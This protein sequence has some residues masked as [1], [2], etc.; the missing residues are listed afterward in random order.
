MEAPFSAELTGSSPDP[1]PDGE[2]TETRSILILRHVNMNTNTLKCCQ[3]MK[4][5]SGLYYVTAVPHFP[6]AAATFDLFVFACE[7]DCFTWIRAETEI[8]HKNEHVNIHEKSEK[9]LEKE[10]PINNL[11]THHSV[12]PEPQADNQTADYS[13]YFI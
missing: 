6:A 3:Y 11:I 5:F 9:E 7:T 13:C 10:N 4:V 2:K 1:R 8:I 12:T